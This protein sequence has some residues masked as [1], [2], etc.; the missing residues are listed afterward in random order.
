MPKAEAKHCS[1]P[2]N[3]VPPLWSRAE[4]NFSHCSVEQV[5]ASDLHAN[6]AVVDDEIKQSR[7]FQLMPAAIPD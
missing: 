2:F 3:T 5:L 1:S 7:E 4:P 6:I